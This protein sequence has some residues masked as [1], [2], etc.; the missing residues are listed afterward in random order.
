MKQVCVQERLCRGLA[1][2]P[3][4]PSTSGRLSIRM[5]SMITRPTAMLPMLDASSVPNRESQLF[6]T[7]TTGGRRGGGMGR[8]ETAAAN[9]C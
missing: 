4:R 8:S 2:P 9:C 6:H 3:G 7:C 5:T 1:Q